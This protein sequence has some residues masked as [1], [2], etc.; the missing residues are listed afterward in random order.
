MAYVPSM[1]IPLLSLGRPYGEIL[2]LHLSLLAGMSIVAVASRLPLVRFQGPRLSRGGFTIILLAGAALMYVALVLN[3]GFR[4]IPPAW[5]EITD[6]R[7][8]QRVA[9]ASAG[10]AAYTVSWLAMVVN[11][12][13]VVLGIQQRRRWLLYLGLLGQFFM[14]AQGGQKSML[15]VLPLI[16][17]V[18]M[19]IRH[20]GKGFGIAVTGAMCVLLVA[21][22]GIDLLIGNV[23]VTSLLVRRAVITPGLLTGFYFDFY[24]THSLMLY[25]HSFLRGIIDNPYVSSPPFVIGLHYFG[26]PETSAN[27]NIWADAYA[28]LGHLGV[29]L[30]SGVVGGILWVIDGLARRIGVR[31]ATLLIVAPAWAMVD[32]A[33]FTSLLTHGLGLLA[34]IFWAAPSPP[35]NDAS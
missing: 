7:M 32:S 13:L 20:T 11:P 5:D 31:A 14:F 22:L 27:A 19:V 6:V 17:G 12:C 35:L 18:D 8:D 25:A 2:P 15:L 10:I 4:L 16:W 21:C 24:S 26:D 34:L 23:Y 28:N 29:L 33:L 30:H 1:L 9:A 3:M